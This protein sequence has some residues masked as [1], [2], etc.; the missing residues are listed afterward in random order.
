MHEKL[1]PKLETLPLLP[2]CY[3]MKNKDN[4]II[5]VGKAKKL[6]NRVNQYFHGTHN[7]KTTKMVS[8]IDDFEY[9]VTGSEKEALILENNLIKKYRPRYNI[10]MM[11]DKTYPYLRLTSEEHPRFQVVRNVKDKK[12][13]HFGPFS[14]STAA[15]DIMKLM[16]RI[17]PLRK[18]THIPKK[19]CLYYH[20]HQC[21]APC[22]NEV[23][24]EEYEQIRKSIIAFMK[25]DIK[26]VMNNLQ[27]QM[28]EASDALDF[29][30]AM[31]IRDLM[32]SIEHMADKQK[33]E[34]QNTH[35]FDV[36]A[37]YVDKGYIAIAGLLIRNGK[38]MQ[39]EVQVFDI[40][41][42]PNEVFLS[43]LMQY[44]ETNMVCKELYVSMDCD[45]SELSEI[46]EMKI[47]QPQRGEK[48]KLVE[49]AQRNAEV[50][51]KQKFD[52]AF[53]VNTKQ[54]VIHQEMEDIF[55]IS[56]LGRIEMFD[57]SHLFGS[58]R[59]SGMI[60]VEEGQ[61]VRNEYRRFQIKSD[62][63]DDLSMM[64]EVVYRRYL[65]LLKEG[66]MMPSVLL[67]DGGMLQ[68]EAAKEIID[69]LE[70]D[71]AVFG[72][73]KDDKHNTS[74][75]LNDQGEEIEIDRKS[76]LFFFLAQMQDEVH[77]YAI[78]YHQNARSKQ[79]VSS[80]LDQIEGIGA[81]RKKALLTYF[82][83]VKKIREASLEELEKVVGKQAA[84]S[85]YTY[86]Q[87]HKKD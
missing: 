56:P 50:L 80:E 21:L 41:G 69:A 52:V 33:M 74:K 65:R 78:S 42:E 4:E 11:D 57:N 48:L 71:I 39:R 40:Y 81:V 61:F 9:I 45:V 86:Y 85:V 47:I 3:L 28:F 27:T 34:I 15:Y 53:K 43:F 25:G 8:N 29:E 19:E 22:I 75:L 7:Y 64:K 55:G 44:Y 73:A 20:M 68:I 18:C 12:A 16:N 26:E 70:L 83:S 51:L 60:V 2:G 63:K 58:Q 76:E 84:Q 49:L 17:Y 59:V 24:T 62:A 6:K 30:R 46:Y 54:S 32:S 67:M 79:L 77:R 82:K 87:E 66:K 38:L 72:L 31:E 37:Y 13:K 5:Y 1:K 10:L 23:R 36:F 14:D 35:D